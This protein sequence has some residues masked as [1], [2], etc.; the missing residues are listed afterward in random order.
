[1]LRVSCKKNLSTVDYECQ[2][3]DKR[4]RRG[5]RRIWDGMLGRVVK[6]VMGIMIK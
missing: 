4:E 5:K 1:M 6:P 2:C 3:D